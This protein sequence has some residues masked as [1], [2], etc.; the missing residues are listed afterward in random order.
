MAKFGALLN[1]LAGKAGLK[2]D[3]ETLKSLLAFVEVAQF[4]LPEEFNN[5]LERNL[6]TAESAAANPQVRN[7]IFAEALDGV[8]AELEKVVGDFEFT[9]TFKGELKAIG[10]NTNEKLRRISL[11]LKDQL[12]AAKEKANKSGDPKDQAQVDALKKQVEDLNTQ[13]GNLTR[14]HQTELENERTKN[15]N[16]KKQYL[17]KSM[18]AAKPLP[19]NGL[20]AD[21]NILTAKTLLEQELAKN[22]LII[23]FDEMGN[24]LLR[25]RKDGGEIEYFVDNKKVDLSTFMDSTLAANKFLQVNPDQEGENNRPGDRQH[26]QHQQNQFPSNTNI[27]KEIEGQLADIGLKV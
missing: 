3:D 11:G 6:L 12:K 27:L 19:K 5:A 7:K 20:P 22:S 21:V 4:E 23:S 15:L 24:P 14:M 10:K 25:Q 2:P 8:D 13:M 9:D 26:Q 1:S 18:L 16:E 17:I